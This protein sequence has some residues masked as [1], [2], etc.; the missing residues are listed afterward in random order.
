MGLFH[1]SFKKRVACVLEQHEKCIV[2]LRQYR[3]S[4]LTLLHDLLHALR[5]AAC[6]MRVSSSSWSVV[7]LLNFRNNQSLLSAK[8]ILKQSLPDV[9]KRRMF[10]TTVVVFHSLAKNFKRVSSDL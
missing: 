10:V 9:T 2:M 6:S 7:I 5:V 1:P 3:E 4:G 8:A